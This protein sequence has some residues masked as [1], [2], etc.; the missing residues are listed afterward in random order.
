MTRT[1]DP[2]IA[3]PRGGAAR[4]L[5]E[6]LADGPIDGEQAVPVGAGPARGDLPHE[7]AL[8]HVPSPGGSFVAAIAAYEVVAVTVN[9]AL[10]LDVLPSV[11][12]AVRRFRWHRVVFGVLAAGALASM[13][14]TIVVVAGAM[15]AR[16]SRS[17]RR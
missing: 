8:H 5:A 7:P 11:T 10:D 6:P 14:A 1:L 16:A 9:R 3:G 17:R 15:V 4:A 2:P 12:T 13:W